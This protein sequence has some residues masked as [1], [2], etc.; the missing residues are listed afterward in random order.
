MTGTHV[1]FVIMY[2]EVPSTVPYSSVTP[3]VYDQTWSSRWVTQSVRTTDWRK[4]SCHEK[5]CRSSRQKLG[6][7]GTGRTF[8]VSDVW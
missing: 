6:V 5:F 4:L 7:V 3:E 2:I 8:S 1:C